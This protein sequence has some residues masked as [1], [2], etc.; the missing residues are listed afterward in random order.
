M[1]PRRTLA[2]RPETGSLAHRPF[3]AWDAWV[4]LMPALAFTWIV[5]ASFWSARVAG[6]I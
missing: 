4:P 3:A 2:Q 1:S 5:I 6:L